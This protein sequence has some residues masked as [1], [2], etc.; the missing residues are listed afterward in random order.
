MA[1]GAYAA[2]M[3]YVLF[4]ILKLIF[5]RVGSTDHEHD[6]DDHDILAYQVRGRLKA[7]A[8][9]QERR[10]PLIGPRARPFSSNARFRWNTI[11]SSPGRAAA[12]ASSGSPS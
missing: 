1:A 8:G 2:V 10:G 3:T 11:T 5:K 9:C 12:A 7:V 6:E 4:K